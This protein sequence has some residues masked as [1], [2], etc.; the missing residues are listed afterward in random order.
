MKI[1]YFGH[2]CF[3]LTS[4]LGRK[5]LF[6]PYQPGAFDGA[7]GYAPVKSKPDIVCITH[8]HA[9]HS[10]LGD[11]SGKPVVIA[12]E[13]PKIVQD[14]AVNGFRTYHD[15]KQGRERGL[16]VLYVVQV[17]GMKIVHCGDLGTLPDKRTMVMI[18][19][20]DVLLVPVGGVF[21][22]T[23]PIAAK[24][25]K[26]LRA[27][28]VFPM[29]YKTPDIGFPLEPVD[30]FLGL[31]PKD[32]VEKKAVSE[33]SVEPPAFDDPMKIIALDYIHS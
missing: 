32:S 15:T 29:H 5:I 31:F 28:Y 19:S 24:L 3:E 13:G 14:V 18:G 17:D 7:V 33:I 1:K 21:T 27:K 10:Y 8:S 16:N 26:T 9:D 12:G 25:A 2:S 22:I 6:D 4:S 11:L 30:K 23:A 20:V